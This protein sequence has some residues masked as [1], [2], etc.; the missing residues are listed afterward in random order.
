MFSGYKSRIQAIVYR[1]PDTFH[2]GVNLETFASFGNA[3]VHS[4]IAF[5]ETGIA[6]IRV[7]ISFCLIGISRSYG[8]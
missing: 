5:T 4:G 2:L 8:G 3:I 6:L 7:G 1:K